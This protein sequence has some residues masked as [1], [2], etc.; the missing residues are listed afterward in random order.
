VGRG[1][2]WTIRLHGNKNSQNSLWLDQ[3]SR[4][5]HG[6]VD[7]RDPSP[8][9]PI[10]AMLAR[11]MRPTTHGNPVWQRDKPICQQAFDGINLLPSTLEKPCNWGDKWL[12]GPRDAEVVLH[13]FSVFPFWFIGHADKIPVLFW[14]EAHFPSSFR[15]SKKI[16]GCNR[17][18][19]L[20]CSDHLQELQLLF[21]WI[22]QWSIHCFRGCCLSE[23]K[24]QNSFVFFEPLWNSSG[25][26]Q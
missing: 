6:P 13:P 16:R 5:F 24:T 3:G 11:M 4:L 20:S 17:Q 8:C 1:I 19:N 14:R 9:I 26:E 22:R 18:D 21:L 12:S 7:K 10:N 15:D 2:D 23:L 25:G